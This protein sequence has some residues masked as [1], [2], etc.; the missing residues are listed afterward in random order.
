MYYDISRN[1]IGINNNRNNIGDNNPDY[2]Y[3]DCFNNTNIIINTLD[4]SCPLINNT[5]SMACT[6]A[7]NNP[8][9]HARVYSIPKSGKD[10]KSLHPIGSVGTSFARCSGVSANAAPPAPTGELNR[11]AY[12]KEF[13]ER[14]R[15]S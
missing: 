6:P 7:G 12:A 13:H 8:N 1:V 4:F 2:M 5:N 9:P 11:Y 15:F 3:C 10:N 14:T